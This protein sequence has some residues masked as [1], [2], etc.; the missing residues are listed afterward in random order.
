MR[1]KFIVAI[2]IL[3]SGLFGTAA[4]A[5][6]ADKDALKKKIVMS[7]RRIDMRI[8]KIDKDMKNAKDDNARASANEYKTKLQANKTDL[9]ADLKA[10]P[11]VKKEGWKDFVDEVEEHLGDAK[12]SIKPAMM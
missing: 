6:D 8:D 1:S 4:H 10:L 9:E 12:D 7:I 3:L 11:D 5:Q 2:F